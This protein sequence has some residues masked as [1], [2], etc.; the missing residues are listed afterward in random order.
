M[1]P[2]TTDVHAKT[3][4]T[5]LE[6][7][8][9]SKKNSLHASPS[10][11]FSV[12]SLQNWTRKKRN[13]NT[14][15]SKHRSTTGSKETLSSRWRQWRNKSHHR[16]DLS[17][18]TSQ[19]N[20]FVFSMPIAIYNSFLPPRGTACPFNSKTLK[21]YQFNGLLA[22]TVLFIL[23]LFYALYQLG[24]VVGLLEILLYG[25]NDATRSLLRLLFPHQQSAWMLLKKYALFMIQ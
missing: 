7:T 11:V 1:A 10:P 12:F 8:T 6:H 20:T 19:T 14:L 23:V 17:L 15:F 25:L 5:T 4:S 18:H 2:N 3:D 21:P 22:C 9:Q 13:P 24:R 16:T